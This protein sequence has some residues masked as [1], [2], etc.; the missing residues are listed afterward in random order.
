MC[1][2]W[3]R[4][5]IKNI[6]LSLMPFICGG[7]ICVFFW[8]RIRMKQNFMSCWLLL[9]SEEIVFIL[10]GLDFACNFYL[11]QDEAFYLRRK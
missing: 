11:C 2:D 4:I 6:H 3:S 10:L 9:F 8:S 5:R 1:F 7:K